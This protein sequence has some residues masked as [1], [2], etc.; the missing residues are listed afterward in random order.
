MHPS[1]IVPIIAGAAAITPW[2]QPTNGT[3]WQ[4]ILSQTLDPNNLPNVQAIDSDIP[5]ATFSS[6]YEEWRADAADFRAQPWNLGDPLD[7]WPGE[8]WVNSRALGIR[9]II[10]NRVAIGLKN[11]ALIVP[12]VVDIV[13]FKVNE[14][15]QKNSPD[16]ANYDECKRYQPFVAWGKPVFEIEYV[17][18][19]SS[20]GDTM[21]IC[22]NP[23]A[24]GFSTLIKKKSLDR[25]MVDCSMQG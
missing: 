7:V 18:G 15:C 5:S 16:S 21:R 22:W 10:T 19:T 4:I 12:Q 3:T 8:R 23:I 11:G 1:G 24:D 13:D 9:A 25:S 14:S 2:W 20:M 17:D 6:Q